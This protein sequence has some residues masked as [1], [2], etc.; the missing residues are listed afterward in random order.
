MGKRPVKHAI[1]P[2]ACR[3]PPTGSASTSI[4]QPAASGSTASSPAAAQRAV[5]PPAI[6]RMCLVSA[7][8]RQPG[9]GEAQEPEELV[10]RMGS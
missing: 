10:E 4:T 7:I 5:D 2:C 8:L 9:L 3:R 6:D 1:A